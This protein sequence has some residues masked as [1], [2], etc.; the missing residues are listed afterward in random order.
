MLKIEDIF[1]LGSFNPKLKSGSY[2]V[3]LMDQDEDKELISKKVYGT[4][5]NQIILKG[6]LEA[7]SECRN[8]SSVKVHLNCSVGWRNAKK[9]TNKA[10]LEEIFKVS[11]LRNI[12]IIMNEKENLS[13]LKD[14]V[15]SYSI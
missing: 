1:I 11:R 3:I 13:F 10:L 4:S 15:R 9:S 8:D 7:L 5:V 14:I 12:E 6:L 2:S